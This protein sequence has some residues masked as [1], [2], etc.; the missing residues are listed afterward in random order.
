MA[1]EAKGTPDTGNVGPGF[2][3]PG[4]TGFPTM[5]GNN[6]N[7]HPEKVPLWN[8]CIAV[9]VII[10]LLVTLVCCIR[11]WNSKNKDKQTNNHGH[12]SAEGAAQV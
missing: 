2:L 10:V 8:I 4:N 12:G 5:G 7:E 11:N 6:N 3:P 9:V 1:F